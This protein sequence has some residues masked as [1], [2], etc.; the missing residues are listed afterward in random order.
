MRR[1]NAAHQGSH[2]PTRRPEIG[3]VSAVQIR[4][5]TKTTHF[6]DSQGE[7]SSARSTSSSLR[8]PLTNLSAEDRF[9]SKVHMQLTTEATHL[10]V[11]REQAS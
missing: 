9:V 5:T 8:K 1:T 2:S 7:T 4:L 3:I 11:S 10:L 6:L